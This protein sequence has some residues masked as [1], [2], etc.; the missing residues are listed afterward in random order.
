MA[1]TWNRQSS[2]TGTQT[3]PGILSTGPAG[4]YWGKI[5]TQKPEDFIFPSPVNI[6]AWLEGTVTWLGKSQTVLEIGPGKADLAY[7]VLSEKNSIKNYIIADIS[8]DILE[9]A[10]ERINLLKPS[11]A[12]QYVKGDLNDPK[13]LGEI[14]AGSVDKVILINVFGYLEPDVALENIFRV[15]RPGGFVRLTMG[16][17]EWFAL[18]EDYDPKTHRQYVR[19]RKFQDNGDVKPLGYTISKK[20]GKKIPYYGF[21]RLYPP[22][23][24]IP[25]LAQH[26]FILEQY[27]KVLIPTALFLKVRSAHDNETDLSEQELRLL[28]ERGGRPIIDLIVRKIG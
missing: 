13:A 23:Q 14:P 1:E 24:L 28:R 17:Y 21:R 16:D 11:A 15:L 7:K 6:P 18:S 22:E 4:E 20:A 9:H 12:V 5:S 26:G 25:I 27:G 3:I 10:E 8:K 19:G 2:D